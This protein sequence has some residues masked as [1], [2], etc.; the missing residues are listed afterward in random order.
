[1]FRQVADRVKDTINRL[2]YV[3]W[4]VLL[5]LKYRIS[6]TEPCCAIVMFHHILDEPSNEVLDSCQCTSQEFTDFCDFVSKSFHVVSLND[7]V[8]QVKNKKEK[9]LV[10]SFDDVPDTFYTKAY[11]I[12]QKYQLPFVLYI[13]NSFID[14]KG[15]LSSNQ[16]K[17][18]SID[19]LCTIGSHS[20]N[21]QFL[22]YSKDLYDEIISSKKELELLISK[23][24]KDFAF[25][26]GTPT[27]INN[28]VI[29]FVRNSQSFETAVTTIPVL[30][31][32][33]ILKN[34]FKLPRIHSR[35]F[36]SKYKRI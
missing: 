7:F 27:A 1:M 20:R 18:L 23:K 22:K 25:P 5:S 12:L 11:P 10:I 2:A 29:K 9:L 21:H 32:S 17:Q 8:Q 14:A 24:V 15:Y 4:Y 26:Y 6:K 34:R 13:A 35:L 31:N 19:P 33:N 36:M 16:I 30:V 28:K 3:L